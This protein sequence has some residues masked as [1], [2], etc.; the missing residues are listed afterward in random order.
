MVK[1]DGLIAI[2]LNSEGLYEGTVVEVI[3]L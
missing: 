1:A 2:D 3:P